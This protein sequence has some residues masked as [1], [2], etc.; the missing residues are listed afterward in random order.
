M[1]LRTMPPSSFAEGPPLGP[2][3]R[4][5]H[6]ARHNR[7]P[8]LAHRPRPLCD[9]LRLGSSAPAPRQCEG[10]DLRHP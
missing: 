1:C 10:C 6:D 7:R 8:A 3:A 4:L 2:A 5:A 9:R